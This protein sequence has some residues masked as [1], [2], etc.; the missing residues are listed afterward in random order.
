MKRK[1]TRW[2][3]VSNMLVNSCKCTPKPYKRGCDLSIFTWRH[4]VVLFEEAKPGD[5]ESERM[6]KTTSG[7][8]LISCEKKNFFSFV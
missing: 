5:Q 7:L 2:T 1:A 3:I 6:S 4:R 8:R